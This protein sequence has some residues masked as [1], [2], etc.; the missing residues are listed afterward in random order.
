MSD[1]PGCRPTGRLLTAA[2]AAMT[3]RQGIIS[4][5]GVVTFVLLAGRVDRSR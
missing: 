5:V 1:S 2:P 3:L 4:V